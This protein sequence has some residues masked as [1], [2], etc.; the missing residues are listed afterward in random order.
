MKLNLREEETSGYVTLFREYLEDVQKLNT[1]LY[2]VLNEHLVTS[3]YDRLQMTILN[4]FQDYRENF[5]GNYEATVIQRW[6]ES[7]GT[8]KDCIVTYQAGEGAEEVCEQVHTQLFD[9]L[10]ELLQVEEEECVITDRPVVTDE[11]I[12]EIKEAIRKSAGAIDELKETYTGKIREKEEENDIYA[13]MLP[14]IFSISGELSRFHAFA[15][16]EIE[17]L[18]EFVQEKT[19]EMQQILEET[20]GVPIGDRP[21]T[22]MGTSTA[23]VAAGSAPESSGSGS[24]GTAGEAAGGGT[25][26]TAG[27]AVS[28]QNEESNRTLKEMTEYLYSTVYNE[29]LAEDKRIPYDVLARIIPVYHRF[30]ETFGHDFE[31]PFDSPEKKEEYIKREYWGVIRERGNR[32][33]FAG[34]EDS[35]F[36]SLSLTNYWCFYTVANLVTNILDAYQT[37]QASEE[38]LIYGLYVLFDPIL[39]GGTVPEERRE[40]YETFGKQSVQEIRKILGEKTDSPENKFSKQDLERVVQILEKLL[41]EAGGID[42][43]N[44]L[45]EKNYDALRGTREIQKNKRNKKSTKAAGSKKQEENGQEKAQETAESRYGRYTVDNKSIQ[46][47]EEYCEE[48]HYYLGAL[49]KYYSEKYG[50]LDSRMDTANRTINKMSTFISSC[51]NGEIDLSAA[52][53]S[54]IMELLSSGFKS[55]T[56][57]EL[58]VVGQVGKNVVKGVGWLLPKIKES[59]VLYKVS[60]KVW[61]VTEENMEL[62]YLNRMMNQYMREYYA[63][64]KSGSDKN[65]M[66]PYYVH[67]AAAIEDNKLR[68]CFE[69][70]AFAT[71]ALMM[72]LPYRV[73][74]SLTEREKRAAELGI[75]LNWL[76]SGLSSKQDVKSEDGNRIADMLYDTYVSEEYV[77]PKTSLN[78]HVMEVKKTQ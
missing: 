36:Y 39:S 14:L 68:R 66:L 69:D 23:A 49:D 11:G 70:A 54:G 63:F 37:N 48:A 57:I 31:V 52:T 15:S 35:V 20:A 2:Q 61:N 75:Y 7:N 73:A 43:L 45:V 72:Q 10:G 62:P 19:A 12:E 28:D 50:K 30:Y 53:D 44:A 17:K 24:A 78:P 26:E 27:E 16:S 59:K 38:N 64:K 65:L 22:G 47:M 40:E 42:K 5:L 25:V 21:P 33:Y 8:L 1:E 9:Q 13:T 3:K 41:D 56:G 71:E 32:G 51:E 29:L 58:G 67:V 74:G 46:M 77:K 6:L 4:M 18:H 60:E 76:R 34:D 55:F